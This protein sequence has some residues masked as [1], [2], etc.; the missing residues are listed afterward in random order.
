[1]SH[2]LISV[3]MTTFKDERKRLLRAIDSILNQSFTNIELIIVF[4]KTDE[5][6]GYVENA[7]DDARIR[8][9]RNDG[10]PDRNH[11]HNIG[12]AAAGGRFVARMDGD[13]FSYPDRLAKQLAF[14]QS[15]PHV[16][17]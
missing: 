6:A 14:M 12:L 9:I 4:E 3:V 10:V 15:N 11:C 13:D 16:G 1:M 5:N 7:R 17:V 8:V 2:A